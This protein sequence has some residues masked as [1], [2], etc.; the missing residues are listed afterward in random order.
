MHDVDCLSRHYN[1]EGLD[2]SLH[3]DLRNTPGLHDLMVLIDPTKVYQDTESHTN[4]F[5]S[6]SSCIKEIFA[7]GLL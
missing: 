3:V 1:V 4:V 2:T 5:L 7:F 6:I